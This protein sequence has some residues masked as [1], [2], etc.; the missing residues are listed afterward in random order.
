MVGFRTRS[1]R[2]CRASSADQGAV[3]NLWSARRS[4]FERESGRALSTW[5]SSGA[6]H[7]QPTIDVREGHSRSSNLGSSRLGSSCSRLGGRSPSGRRRHR[8]SPHGALLD[9][10]SSSR[11]SRRATRVGHGTPFSVKE[12]GARAGGIERLWDATGGGRGPWPV[13]A[14]RA[15]TRPR[16]LP[17]GRP[18]SAQTQPPG[19]YRPYGSL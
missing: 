5:T 14:C 6:H 16:R 12:S 10:S 2:P 18:S 17:I 19:P 3:K 8:K 15:V 1:S 9:S 4:V 13:A 7:I 11:D